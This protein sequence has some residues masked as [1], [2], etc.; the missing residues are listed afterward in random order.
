MLPLSLPEDPVP[1]S[2]FLWDDPPS[3]LSLASLTGAAHTAEP[4]REGVWPGDCPTRELVLG[5]RLSPEPPLEPQ[6][7]VKMTERE[8]KLLRLIC[9]LRCTWWEEAGGVNQHFSS[10]LFFPPCSLFSFFSIACPS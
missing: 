9:S 2:P 10:A 5:R 7:D 8:H 6:R 4:A 1:G 3:G